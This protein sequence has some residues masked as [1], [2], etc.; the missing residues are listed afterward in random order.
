M[1][2][3]ALEIA[4]FNGPI[5]KDRTNQ[6]YGGVAVY[7]RHGIP[8]KR[9]HDLEFDELELMWIEVTTSNGK[10]LLGT[11]YRLP[12]S[13]SDIW[14][15][16]DSNIEKAWKTS[17]HVILVGNINQDMLAVPNRFSNILSNHGLCMK[18]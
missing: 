14:N 13:P 15:I 5:R 18:N 3:D 1:E 7:S 6:E 12:Y 11:I 9:R 8:I 2:Q 17:M 10:F 4:K 16:I